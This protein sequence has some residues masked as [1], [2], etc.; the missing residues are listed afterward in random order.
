[1]YIVIDDATQDAAVVDPYAAQK[2]S[3]AVK[4]EGVNVRVYL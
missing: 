4:A 2:I 3:D 1:M